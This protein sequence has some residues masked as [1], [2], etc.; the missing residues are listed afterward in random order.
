MAVYRP[1]GESRLKGAATWAERIRT[2]LDEGAFTLECQ[3]IRALRSGEVA[4][5]ELLVRMCGEAEGETIPPGAFLPTAE[6]FGLVER[7]DRWVLA[8]ALELLRAGGNGARPLMLGVNLSGRSFGDPELHAFL[9]DELRRTG[10]DPSRLIIEI[11]ETHA[12][13]NLDEAREFASRLTRLGCR[14]ALDDFGTGFGSFHYLKYLPVDF[15]KLDGDFIRDLPRNTSDQVLVKAM[16][17]VAHGLGML[18]I[19]EFVE[20]EATLKILEG[21]GVDYAQGYHVGRPQPVAAL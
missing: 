21:F 3:P 20:T 12:I 6:R 4:H 13:A 14:F 11:T 15:V 1:G 17:D 18:T 5:W 19:A 9:A 2:A 16:A 10:V 7:I 8:R